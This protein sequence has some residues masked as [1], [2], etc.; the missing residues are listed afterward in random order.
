MHANRREEI[1]E[2]KTGDIVA[3]V[4]LKKTTTG[5]T[6]CDQDNPVILEHLG[7]IYIKLN[8]MMP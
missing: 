8:T 1:S 5:D 4:G 6:L 7:D 3:A 2:A